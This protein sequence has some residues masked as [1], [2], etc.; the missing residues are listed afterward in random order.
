MSYTALVLELAF[1]NLSPAFIAVQPV[2]PSGIPGALNEA[3]NIHGHLGKSFPLCRAQCWRGYDD[4]G[5]SEGTKMVAKTPSG[6]N[7]THN[8]V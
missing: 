2:P 4:I 1:G 5:L 7:Y 8:P 6:S 3:L